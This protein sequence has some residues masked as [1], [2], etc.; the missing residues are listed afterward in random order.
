MNNDPLPSIASVCTRARHIVVVTGAGMSAES[1]LS[2]FRG[3]RDALWEKYDPM[4]LATPEAF[5]RDPEL[6]TRWYDWRRQAGLNAKPNAGHVALAEIECLVM[7]RGARFTLLTQNVDRLH[8]RAGSRNVHEL[9]GS[10]HV[11][12]CTSTGR[13]LEPPAEPF[14]EFPPRSPFDP[15]ARLRPA[16]VWFGEPLSPFVL[17]AAREAMETCDLFLSIGTSSVVFPA[18]GFVEHAIR[19]DGIT[20]EV[21]PNE[22]P[23]SGRV[24]HSIRE[25]AG[26]WLPRLASA[27]A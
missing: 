19:R 7:N 10:I 17:D 11:W 18:A 1:G 15:R 26:A 6:V 22:T 24:T 2:T 23:I 21:N 5:E 4:Q 8:H 16:V 12:R 27:L 20:V 13:E 3:P 25:A 14:G 9:H